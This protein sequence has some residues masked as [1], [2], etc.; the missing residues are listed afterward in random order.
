MKRVIWIVLDSVGV[1]ALPDAHEF[2]DAGAHTFD[3]TV[4][5]SGVKLKH[6][7]ALG[8]GNIEGVQSLGEEATPVG[9]YGRCLEKSRGKDTT[10]GHWEMAGAYSKHPLPTYPDGFP[11][12]IMDAFSER[13]GRGWIGNKPA[14]GTAILEELGQEHMHTGKLIIYTSADSVFQIAAHESIIPVE[15]LYEYCRIAREL[16]VGEHGVA[17][18][19]ARPFVGEPGAY[20]RTANRRDFSLVPP[21]AT[22]LDH[23]KEA[24]LPVVGVGKIED[25]FSGQ[26]ITEAIHTQDNMDGVGQT[27]NY[28]QTVESGLIYTNLVEFDSAWGHRNN[29]MGYGQGLLDFDNRLPEIMQAMTENDI[30]IINADHGCD[31]TTPSTDHSREYIPLLIY[32]KSLQQGVNLGTCST[33]ADIGQT[34]ADILE[35]KLIDEGTSLYSKLK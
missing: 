22:V 5:Q 21:K 3:H 30:L 2:G 13:T 28:M 26:G 35:V 31:P 23:I 17:R 18:V 4:E 33:F 1:G 9:N 12:E 7:K 15:T 16:L 34:V 11:K 10:V 19:I 25:I 29:V 32:G 8:M 24:G 20:V 14:S 6:L 27:L